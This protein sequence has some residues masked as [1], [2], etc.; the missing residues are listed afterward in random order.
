MARQ[1]LPLRGLSG[2]VRG[3][4]DALSRVASACHEQPR[5]PGADGSQ[6]SRVPRSSVSHVAHVKSGRN[7]T[8]WFRSKCDPAGGRCRGWRAAER[9]R[10]RRARAERSS[11]RG[12]SGREGSVGGGAL[13]GARAVL[14]SRL[15]VWVVIALLSA[16]A[17]CR[18]CAAARARS[19]AARRPGR[20]RARPGTRAAAR[21]L[22][23]TLARHGFRAGGAVSRP[24]GL[25]KAEAYD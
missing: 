5:A 21:P 23:R 14:V 3:G 24:A 11:S 1:S 18:V 15:W 22:R 17:G 4:T 19:L 10:A 7:V 16:A 20:R 13:V 6:Q 8:L 2:E 12:R 9:S 25:S